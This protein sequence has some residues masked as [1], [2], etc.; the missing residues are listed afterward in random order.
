MPEIP[1]DD[2]RANTQARHTPPR[3][4][5]PLSDAEWAVIEP[6]LKRVTYRGRPLRDARGRINAMLQIA[7]TGLPWRA[8]PRL[9]GSPDTISRHFRRLAQAGLWTRLVGMARAPDA[10]KALKRLDYWLCRAA[11]RAMR[12]LGLAAAQAMERLGALTAM[13]VLPVYMP[14]ELNLEFVRNWQRS[15]I[16]ATMDTPLAAPIGLLK[17]LLSLEKHFQGRPW[18]RR[19]APSDA[20]T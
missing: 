2:L 13:P 10:P 9:A 19:Y 16:D 18:H 14:R 8:V 4:W 1:I 7:V 12:V 20:V 17:R 6:E 11:R 3:R 5:A 15:I